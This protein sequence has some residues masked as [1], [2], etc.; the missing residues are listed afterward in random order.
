[1]AM[2][3]SRKKDAA[4]AP[5]EHKAQ[6][7]MQSASVP[8]PDEAL[9]PDEIVTVLAISAAEDDHIFLRNIFSHSKWQIRCVGNWRAAKAFLRRH[10]MPV[11]I[12]DGQLPDA[13]WKDI[14]ADL[15]RRPE[16]PLLIVS[17][18]AADEFLWA[19]VLNLGGYDVLVKPFD[20]TEVFRVVSL[21]WLHWRNDRIRMKA[22]GSP[23]FATAVGV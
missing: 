6:P 7:L 11:V 13:T 2:P 22:A 5:A 4:K 14:L 15:C 9:K 23:E 20:A 17:S 19:E 8:E 3:D 12:S 21:A 10:R 18:R 1:M 16:R